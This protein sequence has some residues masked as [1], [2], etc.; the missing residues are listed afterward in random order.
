M[1]VLW[2]KGNGQYKI[3][4]FH[5]SLPDISSEVEVSPGSVEPKKYEEVSVVFTDFAGFTQTASYIPAKKLVGELNEIF[6]E[7]DELLL[8]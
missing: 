1:T 7:F 5:V 6:L 4:N 3:S 2:H 8:L